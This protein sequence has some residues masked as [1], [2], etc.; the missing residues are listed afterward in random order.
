MNPDSTP[1]FLPVPNESHAL[2]PGSVTE[3][4]VCIE[5]DRPHVIEV[6]RLL[7]FG[8]YDLTLPG[9]STGPAP[10]LLRRLDQVPERVPAPSTTTVKLRTSLMLRLAPGFRLGL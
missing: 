10:A 7:F 3:D 6:E 2:P 9:H 8:L 4:H 1:W 5:S